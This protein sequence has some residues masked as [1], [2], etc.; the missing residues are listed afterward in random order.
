MVEG[1]SKG[2][3]NYAFRVTFNLN[4]QQKKGRND[5]NTNETSSSQGLRILV[6]DDSKTHQA[7]A[8]AQLGTSNTLTVVGTYDEAQTLLAGSYSYPEGWKGRQQFDVVLADL[9]LPASGRKQGAGAKYAGQEM[10]IGIFLALL[11]AKQG[12]K[13]VAVFTDS[14]HHSHPASACFDI[15]NENEKDKGCDECKPSSMNVEGC[16]LTL[17]N[18]R[19]WVNHFDPADLAKALEYKE[20]S[21]RSDTVTAKNWSAVLSYIL[22]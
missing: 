20:Y 16:S 19:N 22:K 2:T 7:A 12:V 9:L 18:N 8:R 10:P 1:D 5:M 13:H 21:E 14:D 4:K 11:A 17:V 6:I 3:E 15:F